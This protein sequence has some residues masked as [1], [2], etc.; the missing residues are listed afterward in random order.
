MAINPGW[1]QSLVIM[2]KSVVQPQE[3]ATACNQLLF[4]N[5][6]WCVHTMQR[7]HHM[8]HFFGDILKLNMPGLFQACDSYRGKRRKIRQ[9]LLVEHRDCKTHSHSSTDT[10]CVPMDVDFGCSGLP[11]TDF[12]RAG[13]QLR[14]YGPTNVIYM[15]HGKY[16]EASS[17]PVFIIECTPASWQ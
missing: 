15:T 14:K 1:S 11:C 8:P 2:L 17:V 16:C 10:C 3:F 9:S 5:H 6:R 13:K 7:Y 4:D 12:S